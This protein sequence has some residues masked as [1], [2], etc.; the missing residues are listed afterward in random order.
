MHT[1]VCPLTQADCLC[2]SF[3]EICLCSS[4]H[5]PSCLGDKTDTACRLKY[6][7]DLQTEQAAEAQWTVS[8]FAY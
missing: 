4:E 6:S 2:Y 3:N 8:G 5:K 1:T 7:A